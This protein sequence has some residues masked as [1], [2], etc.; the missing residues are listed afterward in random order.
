MLLRQQPQKR[1]G[2]TLMEIIVV[3]AIIL[4]LAGAAV[5]IVP[6]FLDDARI[7]RAQVDVKTLE[8]AVQAYNIKNPTQPLQS[9]DVLAQLQQDGTAAYISP[10]SLIDP[11]GQPY[12]LDGTPHPTTRVPLIY[13]NGAPGTNKRI[14]NWYQ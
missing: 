4:V 8:K 7:N 2:F 13:S 5:M 12:V 9:L 10:E 1:T 11:W 3:V 6:R 14:Q